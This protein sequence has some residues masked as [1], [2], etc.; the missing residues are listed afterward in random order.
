MRRLLML[1]A[2]MLAAALSLPFAGP[3]QQARAQTQD[4]WTT[5]LHDNSRDGASADA[6]IPASEAPALTKLWSYATGG[7]IASQPAIV[8]G[9]AYVGSWDGY[10]YALNAA[11]G[12][13]TWK[14]FTGIT[15]GNSGCNPPTAGISSAATV[16]NGVVYVGGGDAYWYALDAATGSVLWRV[17]TG[18]NSASGGHYNWSSPLIVNGYAYIGVSSLGDCPLVQGQLLQVSL[19]THQI[20]NT[21]NLVPNGSQ[22]GGIWTSPAYDPALNEI[23][24]VTGTEANDSQTY[25]QAVIGINASTLAVTDYYHLPEQQAVPDSDWTTSTGLYTAA[26]GT[27][28]LVTTNKNGVTYAFNRTSLAAG[29]IWQHQ[30]A[31]GNDCPVCGYSTVSSAAIANGMVFQ[32]GGATTI[33]GTGYGGSVQALDENTGAVVWQHPEAGPVIG[34]ITYMNG[35]V[36]AYA[37]TGFE[38]LDATTGHRLYSYDAGRWSYAAPAVAGGVIITGTVAGT[39]YAFGL[40]ATLPSPPPAD[41]NC[42][43]G[44]TC[45]DIGTTGGAESVSG[46]TWTVTAAGAGI[47]GTSDQFRLMS[48][49][50]A[51]DVQIVARVPSATAAQAGI[52]LRQSND[53]GSPYYGIF[54]TSAGSTTVQYRKSFGGATTVANTVATAGRYLEI[55]RQGDLL[56]A[57]TSADGTTYTAVPGSTATVLMPYASLAGLAA[58]GGTA[59]FDSFAVGAVSNTPQAVPPATACPS[60]WNCGDVGYP[61]TVG[62]Q[63]LSGTTWTIS[64]AGNGIGPAGMTD[65][66]HY[67]WT[68]VTAD[69]TVS[70]HLTAFNA[71]N[72]GAKAGVMMR[73]G[74]GGNAPYYGAFLTP[75][76][77][78]V[79]MERDTS[80]LPSETLTTVGGTAPA[81]LRITRSGTAFTTYT[82]PDGATWTPVT[83]STDTIPNLGGTIDAGEAVT[84][85]TA[86]AAATATADVLSVTGSAAPP[87][88]VCPSGWTCAD[89]GAPIPAGSNYLVGGEWSLLGGGKDIW[90]TKDEFHYT[91]ET[92]PGDATISAEITSQQDTDPWAK[93][94]LMLRASTDPGAAYYAIMATPEGNGTVIQYRTASGGSTTQLSGVTG[95]APIWVEVTRTGATFTAYTS[96]DGTNWTAYPA[97]TVTIP[98]L[99]GSILGGMADTSH[100]QFT[101]S[102]TVFDHF[103]YVQAGS[104][105]PAPWSDSD[106]GNPT[107]AGSASYAS[108]VFTVN[109]GGNDIWAT[110]D[111]FNYVSQS[112]SGDGSIVARVTSQANTSAWAKSGIMIKQSTTAGSAYALLA[113]TP[114]NGV[115]FQYGYNSSVGG[116]SYTFPNAWLKLTRTGSVITAYTS[117]DG[118]TWTQV[119]TTTVNLTAPVTVGLFVTSH[120]AES[121]NTSTFDNVAVASGGSTLPVPWSDS[122]VGGPTPAGSA[123]YAGGV[124][125]VNGG[126]SD[127]WGSQDQFNYVSQP[128]TGN[129]SIVARVTAQTNTD[130]WAKSGVMIKQSTTAGS[131]YALLAVTPGNGVAFQYGYN[132][133][134]GGGSYTFPNAWL[135]LTRTD[136]VITAYTSADGITWTQV[137]TATLAL[138]DPVT[139]GIFVCSHNA[140]SL[141]TSTFDSVSVTTP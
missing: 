30:T 39:I 20:V 102:T 115:A 96:T 110:L 19:S 9:V 10:E 126:G 56:T 135:K 49:P 128:L 42:P 133:S 140:G 79:V 71:T 23:F 66:F 137:G 59:T 53:P 41:P 123:S 69:T 127:I 75:S 52:M 47:T 109:G 45:Q 113:V 104:S 80:G 4:D 21:L 114:G 131:A 95:K 40:P 33:N 138:T 139:V 25:A 18:D 38:V 32:A 57:A 87:P 107:P 58:S 48:Q 3:G 15:T 16:L 119:G 105:L 130:L 82:S 108:G 13:V 6:V 7:T 77:G 1:G 51:G 91:A 22:G 61:L 5:S 101:T 89:I 14:T 54:V 111:Q 84:S 100:S 29:P 134:V 35:M 28:M 129:G 26:N 116:G 64:G 88:T 17:Y 90:G 81:Y 120:N 67:V 8:G 86:P 97:S 124:F 98:A 103:T 99:S 70:T 117:A 55:Q 132:S 62:N 44:D 121:L 106:V 12:A 92:V 50:S 31:I 24:T 72:A 34:A 118:T 60:G 141:N 63:S 37:G 46:G 136:S 74:T 36:I 43:S 11:T 94:G 93:S 73:A 125:T 122:D 76:S 112:L 2:A 65:Q 78:I 83:G 85:A 27:P 68:T